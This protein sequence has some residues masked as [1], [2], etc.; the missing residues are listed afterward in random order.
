MSE[1]GKKGRRQRIGEAHANAKLT[2]AQVEAIRAAYEAGGTS[3]KLLA[4]AYGVGK[5]TIRD[6]VVFRRRASTVGGW[7]RPGAP[8]CDL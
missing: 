4:T 6:I 5:S 7:K 2:D 1:S 8:T 3:Y